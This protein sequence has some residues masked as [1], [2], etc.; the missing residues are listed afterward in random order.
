MVHRLGV[1]ISGRGS[2]LQA[3]IDAV[4]D[5]RLAAEI[6]VVISNV[7][8]AGGLARAASAGIESIV[9]P[10]HQWPDRD[11]FDGALAAALQRRRVDLVC[12]AG[13][14]RLL[15]P[16]FL[17]AFPERV[18][19][20]HPSLL[21]AFP[22]L[23]AQQQAFDY[24]VKVTGATVHFVSA[25][26]DGGPIVMQ[27]AVP[28]AADDTSD[29]LSARILAAEHRLYPQAIKRVLDGQGRLDGRRF[30]FPI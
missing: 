5:K 4:T 28:V 25:E 2:N 22:G 21:P 23:D 1:L 17:E 24:G 20:I 3:I 19:N 8:E 7:A 12:L 14:M 18:L 11:A 15:G 29:A 9:M 10:Q 26:L 30:L 13:F 16:A 27:A 6:A